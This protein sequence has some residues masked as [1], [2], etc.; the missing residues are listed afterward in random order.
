MYN[1]SSDFEVCFVKKFWLECIGC[2][3]GQ[4]ARRRWLT[5]IALIRILRGAEKICSE[6]T[7]IYTNDFVTIRLPEVTVTCKRCDFTGRLW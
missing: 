1:V 3:I 4:A 5:K 2:N 7:R 6:L